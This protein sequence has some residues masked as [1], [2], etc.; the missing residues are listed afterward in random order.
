M[1]S[2]AVQHT[3]SIWGQNESDLMAHRGQTGQ[4]PQWDGRCLSR[5]RGWTSIRPADH[6]CYRPWRGRL[7]QV[8]RLPLE[9]T[10]WVLCQLA[11][12]A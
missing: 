5:Y 8:R 7:R 4:A 2:S 12:S 9:M 10:F 1:A 11:T 3:V 6:A